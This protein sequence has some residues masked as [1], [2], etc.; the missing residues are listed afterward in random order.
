VHPGGTEVITEN[1]GPANNPCPDDHKGLGG[2]TLLDSKVLWHH[3]ALFSEDYQTTVTNPALRAPIH[4][5][6]RIRITGYYANKDYAW[7]TAMTH[8]GA[9]IDT[10]QPPK[11]RC[12]PYF[13]GGKQEAHWVTKR[14]KRRVTYKI[15]RSGN[16]VRKV[17]WVKKRVRVGEELTAGVPNRPWGMHDHDSLC[18]ADL[19]APPCD[20]PD[21]HR[22][23]G[24]FTD[25]VTISNFLYTPGDMGMNGDM[26]N[27]PRVHFGQS[28][29][30]VN[31]D[32]SA[33]I[34]HSVTT[35]NAPCNGPYVGNY[36]HANGIWDSG[37]LGYDAIDGGTPDPV[38]D[39]PANLPVG[40]YTYFCRIHPWMRGEFDVV[41]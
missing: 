1:L 12:K 29:R 30:F 2:T 10:A 19:G 40:R 11:G 33:D 14:I 18:G 24:D 8:N 20:K 39:T 15:S 38:A 25:Q 13:V 31:A 9:Y 26:G 34:R 6:D 28:L 3:D 32:Q 41:P 7:Y 27:P 21:T 16:L 36:P 37:T 23:P 22:P 35:C 5:G 17:H 4:K